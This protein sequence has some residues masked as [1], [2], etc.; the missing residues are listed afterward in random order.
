MDIVDVEGLYMYN[1]KVLLVPGGFLDVSDSWKNE[2]NVNE[3]KMYSVI[4][5]LPPLNF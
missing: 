4:F 5:F 3:L 1:R 2:Y